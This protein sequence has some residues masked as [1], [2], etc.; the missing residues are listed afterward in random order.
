MVFVKF[1][2]INASFASS[3]K[4]T[5][6]ENYDLKSNSEIYL[7]YEISTNDEF[8]LPIH[9]KINQRSGFLHVYNN[10]NIEHEN[11]NVYLRISPRTGLL[12]CDNNGYEITVAVPNN[13]YENLLIAARHGRVPSCI[14]VGF[15]NEVQHSLNDDYKD[16][17][18]LVVENINFSVPLAW[19]E[20]QADYSPVTQLQGRLLA[21]QMKKA[22]TKIAWLI[23][24][25]IILGLLK[26]IGPAS[27]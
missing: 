17:F 15:N 5:V 14:E 26:L 21:Q 24:V 7:N 25:T 23:A 3:Y 27:Q 8:G 10:T 2:V 6:D 9:G 13:Q 19:G 12:F 16:A 22:N 20:S 11:R 18:R 4:C 1:I